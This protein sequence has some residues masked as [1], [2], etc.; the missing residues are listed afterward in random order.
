MAAV[1]KPGGA[2][3]DVN[4]R[5][6]FANALESDE[7]KRNRFARLDSL[8]QALSKS[9]SEAIQGRAQ[10][11]V[12]Q[13]WREDEEFYQGIDDAN[14][15][16]HRSTWHTKPMAQAAATGQP[17]TPTKSTVFPNITGPY[18]DAGAARIA[19]MLLPTDD[20]AWDLLPTPI[21]EL[22]GL[23]NGEIPQHV[24]EAALQEA[25][26]D[27]ELASTNLATAIDAAKKVNADAKKKSDKARTR[28]ED[29][30]VECQ[31]HAQERQ[32]IEDAARIGT[33]VLKGPVPKMKRG[34][35]YIEG[36]LVL[37][38]KI[39][40]ASVR[41]DPWNFFPDPSC[42]ENIQNGAYT[43]E[44]DR[45]TRKQLRDLK[46][47]PGYI[48]EHIDLCMEE[49][50]QT[51]TADYVERGDA[52][53]SGS[54]ERSK[55]KFEIWYYHGTLEK[56]D[57]E[58]AGCDCSE[59]KDAHVPALM[60]MVNNRVIRASL[61]PL[62]TGSFPYDVMVWR[63]RANHWTGIGIARQ[64]RTPQRI[65][66]AATRNLMDNA[67]LAAGP[68]VVVKD[69]VVTPADGVLGLGPRKIWY[70]EEDA[71]E[72]ADVKSVFS[73]IKVDMLVA[74]LMEIIKLGLKLAEDVTGMPLLLQGQQERI[75]EPLGTTQIRNNN[76]SAVL[77][78]LA[79]LFDDR[80][81]EPHV[82]RYYEWLLQYGEDD[83]KGDFQIDARGSS[84]LV[85][86]DIQNQQLPGV[87]KLSLDMRFGLDPRKAAQEYLKS[88]HFDPK[89]FE[90]EDEEWKK[91]IEQMS[92]GPQDQGLQI[93]QLKAQSGERLADFWSKVEERAAAME[94]EFAVRES[95]K[96]RLLTVLLAEMEQSGTQT[97]SLNDLKARLTDTTIRTQTQLKLSDR[98]AAAKNM[99]SPPVEPKG[100][101][102]PGRSYEQ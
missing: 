62:D 100:R 23:A 69:G 102:R 13:D 32:M 90:F 7:Q 22:I 57:L 95:E 61:N 4:D 30:H 6:G 43:F 1:L 65:V 2:P 87:I 46:K 77:R 66:T 27:A 98:N 60:T 45:I 79:R 53:L 42:G 78:R 83:E 17:E 44:R 75:D 63:P 18:V 19:D 70:I 35:A 25:G 94:K 40:P 97:I 29:W 73:I 74:E 88:L 38:Q 68:M 39:K 51:A 14:R 16:E 50:A 59:A 48:A 20:R 55:N 3:Q 64:I 21:P 31:Y 28:I 12:E 52:F 71:D 82:R 10:S 101:A 37:D 93:A 9:R 5:E 58:A 84:A 85:E 15:G 67:G 33:G 26:G 99:D 80:V 96:D 92:R 11:G 72:I 91:I 8:G 86:R 54:E 41:V 24:E 89:S 47:Q 34:V 36:A 76:A 81:T 56:A 49:G